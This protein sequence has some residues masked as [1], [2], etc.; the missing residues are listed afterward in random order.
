M[1]GIIII[2]EH[3]FN[4]LGQI[5][6][7]GE[8][9]FSPIVIWT[10]PSVY[11]PAGSRYVGTFHQVADPD[12]GV[13]LL[14]DVYRKGDARYAV[15]TDSDHVMALLDHHYDALKD[16]F[17]FFNAG[18][19]DRLAP[20][21]QKEE[22][23][24]WA[25]RNGLRIPKTWKVR[26]GEIPNDLVFPVFTKATDSFD[27]HW[28]NVSG[29]FRSE[30]ALRAFYAETTV[31]EILLQEYIEKRN[32]V[33]VEGVSFQGGKDFFL[34]VQGEYLRLPE[35]GFGTFKRNEAYRLGDSLKEKIR[36]MMEEVGFNGIF[37]MEF[38]EG[39]DGA[40][41]YLETNFRQTQ[42]NHALAD[43]GVNLSQVWYQSCL[44]GK[45]VIEGCDLQKSPA[46]VMNEIKDYKAYVSTG[47]ISM[48]SWLRDLFR[49]DSYYFLDRRDRAFVR[50]YFSRSIRLNSL[51][52]WHKLLK[53]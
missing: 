47:K 18:G 35:G 44:A 38:L 29:I 53:H 40:L 28:K 10:T 30:D 43:M 2:G 50:R 33:A 16:H 13:Q 37:E 51:N 4:T 42:Y 32:E 3:L 9:G 1:T 52:L 27:Y 20:Y 19:P 46:L 48:I 34:P 24:R 49:A 45:L 5:R 15:S 12:A 21:L 22:Q 41:Y 7:F 14:L 36:R 25:E 26:V 6:C 17:C 39:K 11:T 23:C 31:P 8:M